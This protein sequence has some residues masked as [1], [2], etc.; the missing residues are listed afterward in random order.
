MT[1]K[2]CVNRLICFAAVLVS[3]LLFSA[4]KGVKL[5]NKTE[6]IEEYTKAQAMIILANERNRY[7]NAYSPEIWSIRVEEKDMNFDRLL[8][9]NV[10]E[11]LQKIKLLC[12]LAEERGVLVNSRE[13]DLIRQMTDDYMESLDS[14]D[15]AFIGCSREDVQKMYTDYFT[16]CK[17][18]E[19][20]AAGASVD[21]SDSEVK[22][23]KIMQIGTADLKKAKAIL[24]K[25]KIDGADFNSMASRYSE[26]GQIE[27]E[28]KKGTNNDLI[29]KTAFSLDEG[30]ISNIL[31]V[32]GMYYIIKCVNGYDREGTD[33]RKTGLK[34]AVSTLKFQ[35][36]LEPYSREHNIVFF[37]SFWNE[38]DLS[39]GADSTAD[40]FFDIY[41]LYKD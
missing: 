1:R 25:V 14:A 16:A 24:K 41:E 3:M 31:G 35:E 27:V 17:M 32:S 22:V 5:E 36:V 7:Q 40:G 20:L 34:T 39:A 33:S 37:D 28:L 26:L 21:I 10:K 6:Q 23:I 8:T 30:G 38:V 13:R 12:L 4:C 2:K 9:E 15:L 29:E 11:Y 18:A 19:T